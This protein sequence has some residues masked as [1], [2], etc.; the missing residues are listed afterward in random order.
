MADRDEAG[1]RFQFSLRTF[2]IATCALGAGG[3]TLGRLFLRNPD[4]FIVVI[5]VLSSIVPFILAIGTIYW[6]ATRK[7]SI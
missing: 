1:F 3:G 2:L 4:T 7:K 6:I 5:G